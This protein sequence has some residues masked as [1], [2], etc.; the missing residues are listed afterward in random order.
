MQ[1]LRGNIWKR[2]KKLFADKLYS[3]IQTTS[4]ATAI[5]LYK[6]L[7]RNDSTQYDLSSSSLEFLGERLLIF[8]K[9]EAAAAIFQLAVQE[10][11]KY[12]YGYFYLG[13]AYEKWG[14][15]QE[16]IE[17]YQTAVKNDK[18]SRPGIDAAFQ[19]NYLN[20]HK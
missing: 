2:P 6:N 7:K 18:N 1:I 4:I 9:Y 10:N 17:A 19:I 11:P 14:K 20:G 8:L 12:T 3:V 13:K 16:A 5:S 15:R